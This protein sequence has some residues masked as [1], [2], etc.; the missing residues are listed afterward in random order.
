V[1]CFAVAAWS[2]CVWSSCL[3]VVAFL[4]GLSP[5]FAFVRPSCLSCGLWLLL[6]GL[7]FFVPPTWPWLALGCFAPLACFWPALTY[8]APLSWLSLR[9]VAPPAWSWLLCSLLGLGWFASLLG[10]GWFALLA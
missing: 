8:V 4:L 5:A 1:S 10:L 6:L 7:S 2:Q 3:V 9:C